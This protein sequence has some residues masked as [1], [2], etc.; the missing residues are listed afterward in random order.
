MDDLPDNATASDLTALADGSLDPA[1]RSDVLAAVDRSPE[2]AAALAEQ[3]DAVTLVR[4]VDVD[5]PAELHRRVGALAGAPRRRRPV[6]WRPGLAAA[7]VTVGVAVLAAAIVIAT[8][9]GGSPSSTPSVGRAT[10]LTLSPA[11]APAPVK[12]PVH[13]TEL[14]A[15]VDGVSFPYWEDRFGWRA[16]G[17]R[18]DSVGG[19]ALTT[20]FYANARG[21]RIGYAILAGP[22]PGMRAGAVA[23]RG[24]VPFRLLSQDGAHV[25]TWL[26]AGRLC[27]VAGRGV[28]TRTLLRLA[29]WS[30][31]GPV[32]S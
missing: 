10:A 28:D 32:V 31:E 18:H 19:R 27:V 17:A 29:S 26:R 16:V 12:S 7:G 5:A 9:G 24:G 13:R 25:V 2:L 3:R 23:W 20:V 22:P 1:R 4:S 8:G 30:G 11:T 14:A 15:A 6:A 21:Q